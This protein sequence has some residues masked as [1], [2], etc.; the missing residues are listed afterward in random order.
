MV[1][2][3]AGPYPQEVS[4]V[5]RRG[6]SARQDRCMFQGAEMCPSLGRG[7]GDCLSGV[8][9]FLAGKEDLEE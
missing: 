8:H 7:R 6:C 4:P 9:R 2:Q 1:S 3:Y 5:P